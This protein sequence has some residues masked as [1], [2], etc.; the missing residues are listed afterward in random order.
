MPV[1][2]IRSKFCSKPP[3]LEFFHDEIILSLILPLIPFV[4]LIFANLPGLLQVHPM[5]QHLCVFLAPSLKW[6]EDDTHTQIRFTVCGVWQL[7]PT[8]IFNHSCFINWLSV[9]ILHLSFEEDEKGGGL[10]GNNQFSLYH[11]SAIFFKSSWAELDSIKQTFGPQS[12]SV[13]PRTLKGCLSGTDL[14][15]LS[16][17]S[18]RKWSTSL[19]GA[20]KKG[21]L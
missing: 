1:Q 13:G 9:I 7:L 14:Y 8:G 2:L 21:F 12:R 15:W 3:T 17:H 6:T 19:Y 10:C 4:Y 18:Y 16:Q 11:N 20:V 5:A